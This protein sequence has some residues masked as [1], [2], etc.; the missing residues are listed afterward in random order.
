MVQS[1]VTSPIA[2]EGGVGEDDGGDVAAV[3][4]LN[5]IVSLP[6]LRVPLLYVAHSNFLCA[7]PP[8][9]PP[10]IRGALDNLL[11]KKLWNKVFG[12]WYLLCSSS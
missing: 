8:S 1:G 5:L 10:L 9:R 2:G 12:G 6:Q 11:G 7:L 3:G 4:A